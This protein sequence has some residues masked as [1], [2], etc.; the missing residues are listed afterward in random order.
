V[1]ARE[2][3]AGQKY[4]NTLAVN[5]PCGVRNSKRSPSR[6]VLSLKVRLSLQVCRCELCEAF[7]GRPNERVLQYFRAPF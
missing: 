1:V 2:N 4:V 6:V 7:Q 5:A 3:A